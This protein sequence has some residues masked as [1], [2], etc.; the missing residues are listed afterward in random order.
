[1]Q[2]L[3]LAAIFAIF[4]AAGYSVCYESGETYHPLMGSAFCGSTN[5]ETCRIKH[6]DRDIK[7]SW[8]IDTG[9][10]VG[11]D[12]WA[13]VGAYNE[14]KDVLKAEADVTLLA[15]TNPVSSSD[16]E[17]I[18]HFRKSNVPDINNCR[19][20]DTKGSPTA[21]GLACLH[22]IGGGYRGFPGVQY[23]KGHVKC[24]IYMNLSTAD[25]IRENTSNE[26]QQ[27]L[28]ARTLKHEMGHCLGLN[29]HPDKNT[30]MYAANYCDPRYPAPYYC[31]IDREYEL[32]VE[33]GYEGFYS[34]PQ[35]RPFNSDMSINWTIY[36]NWWE[37]A[38]CASAT[39]YN[40]Q[41]KNGSKPDQGNKKRDGRST[42]LSQT[43]MYDATFGW[44]SVSNTQLCQFNL[45]R[46]IC[47]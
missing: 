10:M 19:S 25:D 3:I 9:A 38:G 46:V 24:H 2:R 32:D 41:L 15:T 17:I 7:V 4:P 34:I 21:N 36:E 30:I 13:F 5:S 44:R 45:C 37:E 14:T 27:G 22:Q 6:F 1:M 8:I 23:T 20:G 12:V 35:D 33:D 39:G 40:S 11:N 43:Q 28:V 18:I 16:P 47:R 42:C 29:H 26:D 31:N